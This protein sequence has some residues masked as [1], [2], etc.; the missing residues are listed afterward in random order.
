[1][2]FRK[3]VPPF[4]DKSPEVRPTIPAMSAQGPHQKKVG[5]PAVHD[6]RVVLFNGQD[7][8]GADLGS[9]PLIQGFVT[10]HLHSNM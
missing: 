7:D 3:Q 10:D 6:V 8:L 9:I 1:M 5:R 2:K 4:L